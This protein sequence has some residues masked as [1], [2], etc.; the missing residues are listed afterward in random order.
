MCVCV[1]GGGLLDIVFVGCG[2]VLLSALQW[3]IQRKTLEREKG[4]ANE[5]VLA[6]EQGRLL[7]GTQTNFYAVID[8]E[9]WTAGNDLVLP[10]T[11]RE[12]VLRV[13]ERNSIPVRF[14]PPPVDSHKLGVL[15]RRKRQRETDRQRDAPHKPFMHSQCQCF[16]CKLCFKD[17]VRQNFSPRVDVP[18]RSPHS[19]SSSR[20]IISSNSALEMKK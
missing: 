7:E 12:I 17:N 6:D 18:S 10:G 5:V 14:E 8:G 19:L 20:S 9:L 13:C 15:L 3:V 4:H 2:W 11:I 1:G 16:I